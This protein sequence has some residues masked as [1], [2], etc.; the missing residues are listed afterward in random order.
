[1]AE[2]KPNSEKALAWLRFCVVSQLTYGGP[3]DPSIAYRVGAFSQL[4]KGGH[5]D[6]TERP[7]S[8]LDSIP[9]NSPQNPLDAIAQAR[10]FE[11]P[12]SSMHAE[13]PTRPKSMTGLRPHLSEATPHNVAVII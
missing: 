9:L 3:G 11:N 2:Q 1:M 5:Y 6:V 7:S 4:L 8:G 13:L 12:K 10:D